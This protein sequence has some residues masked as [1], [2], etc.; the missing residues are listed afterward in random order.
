MSFRLSRKPASLESLNSLWLLPSEPCGA[1]GREGW[2]PLGLGQEGGVLESVKAWQ[3]PALAAPSLWPRQSPFHTWRL[4]EIWRDQSPALPLVMTKAD[5]KASAKLELSLAESCE[6]FQ[7]LSVEIQPF[8]GLLL[9]LSLP[10]PPPFS[11]P[12]LHLKSAL[13]LI[14]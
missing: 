10:L 3:M 1:G 12:S 14:G 13:R 4:G 8:P 11:L 9:P 5:S 2:A 7:V 6:I